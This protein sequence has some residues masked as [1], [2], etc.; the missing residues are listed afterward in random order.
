[1]DQRKENNMPVYDFSCNKCQRQFETM[2]SFGDYETFKTLKDNVPCPSCAS[3]DVEKLVSKGTSFQYRS[4]GYHSTD[5]GK[6]GR[7]R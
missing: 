5:Y 4:G 7:K 6:R 3:T 1:M 2:I